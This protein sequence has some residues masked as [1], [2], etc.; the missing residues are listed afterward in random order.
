MTPDTMT[1]AQQAEWA[2]RLQMVRD[3][4]RG[5]LAWSGRNGMREDKAR[6]E[7]ARAAVLGVWSVGD[8]ADG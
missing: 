8:K 5:A 4:A 2:E 1:P 6:L 7:I 3:F